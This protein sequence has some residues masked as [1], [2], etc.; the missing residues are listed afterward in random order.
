MKTT[1]TGLRAEARVAEE[2]RQ[3]GH[4]IVARNWKTKVCEIDIIAKKEDVVYFVE[5][6]HRYQAAQGSGL[7]HITQQKLRRM[8]FAARV[9]CLHQSWEGD[10]AL[11][12]A[13]VAGPDFESVSITEISN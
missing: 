10:C 5:V 11:L 4:K 13:E 9:W 7:E 12:A 2:L 8:D 6:K 3:Q 1:E